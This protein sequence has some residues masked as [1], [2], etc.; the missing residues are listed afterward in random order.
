MMNSHDDDDDNDYI[1][2]YYNEF[3]Q[4]N[5]DD[6]LS[7][8]SEDSSNNGDEMM[9]DD[10]EQTI[11]NEPFHDEDA[12]VVDNSSSYPI[13]EISI[14][15]TTLLP[16]SEFIPLSVYLQNAKRDETQSL[17]V[18]DFL[19]HVINQQEQMYS[20]AIDSNTQVIEVKYLIREIF[21]MFR[22][23][24]GAVFHLD[25]SKLQFELIRPIAIPS[26]TITLLNSI[27][28]HFINIG[29]DV[30]RIK[31]FAHKVSVIPTI[32]QTLQAFCHSIHSVLDEEY[33]QLFEMENEHVNSC[34]LSLLQ[35]ISNTEHFQIK[36]NILLNIMERWLEHNERPDV[37]KS[38]SKKASHLL[39]LLYTDLYQLELV[40]TSFNG[41]YSFLCR[42]FSDTLAPY[43]HMLNDW[44]A[45]ADDISNEL[46]FDF[47]SEFMIKPREELANMSDEQFWENGFVLKDISEIPNFLS[48]NQEEILRIGKSLRMILYIEKQKRMYSLQRASSHL[49]V[50]EQDRVSLP[51]LFKQWCHRNMMEQHSTLIPDNN[52][53]VQM[54][55]LDNEET[56]AVVEL[57][58]SENALSSISTATVNSSFAFPDLQNQNDQPSHQLL[59]KLLEMRSLN[60]VLTSDTPAKPDQPYPID[61]IIQRSIISAI[62]RRSNLVC[63]YLVSMLID[64]CKLLPHLSALRA[65]YLMEAGDVMDVFSSKLFETME[66]DAIWNNRETSIALNNALQD[67]LK[68]GMSVGTRRYTFES[69]QRTF[70]Y[71]I[72][73]D[74]DLLDRLSIIVTR[75]S[76]SPNLLDSIQLHYALD[77]PLNLLITSECMQC[78]NEAFIFNLKIKYAKY[79]IERIYM[80]RNQ[81]SSRLIFHRFQLLLAKLKHF[82]NNVQ[83]YVMTRVLHSIWNELLEGITVSAQN[84]DQVKQYHMQYIT[85]IQERCLLKKASFVMNQITRILAMCS[86]VRSKY[87]QFMNHF[88]RHHDLKD[89]E[90]ESL[91][92]SYYSQYTVTSASSSARRL[93]QQNLMEPLVD[94]N[95][96]ENQ[97]IIEM[98]ILEED[99]HKSVKML[100]TI[101]RSILQRGQHEHLQDLNNRLNF[102][103]YYYIGDNDEY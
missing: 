101:I 11:H 79:L 92:Q 22:G 20:F 29:N 57:P 31:K 50:L 38:E 37:K 90:S 97:M 83:H 54:M 103:Y 93:Q 46:P 7:D 32:S 86:T 9:I 21:S 78:Y 35:L 43:L 102:N 73:C 61:T 59:I 39:S 41:Q 87:N 88:N 27:L 25:E 76:S 15:D 95:Q 51:D 45:N 10:E 68:L 85:R 74:L 75:D 58:Q 94:I 91:N 4:S 67:T 6:S 34:S 30:I 36:V 70:S 14:H 26:I 49:D 82:V 2:S 8:W 64:D 89:E 52:I 18:D 81:R 100:L 56:T 3:A 42:V 13:A 47:Q 33:K 53:E 55:D 23:I 28:Q 1:Q 16:M 24:S 71:D 84:F 96:I 80:P 40:P 77:E 5:E 44:I 12:L 99:F 48:S 72:Y 19:A 17:N 63:P 66:T 65:F 69:K 62:E 98:D 60:D